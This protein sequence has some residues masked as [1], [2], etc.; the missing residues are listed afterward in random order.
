MSV[1]ASVLGIAMLA[2][3]LPAAAQ[4]RGTVEFGAFGSRSSYDNSLGMSAS[5]GGGARIG[6]FLLPRLSVEFEAGGSNAGRTLGLQDVNVGVLSAR[7]TA[8]PVKA[9]AL[10]L[11]LGA[12]VD[13]IDTH[14]LESYGVHGLVG[15]KLALTQSVALRLDGILSHLSNGGHNNKG[16]HLGLVVYRSPGGGTTMVRETMAATPMMTHSDSVSASETARL[17]MASANYDALRDSL[18]RRSLGTGPAPSSISALATMQQVIYFANDRSDL[19]DSARAILGEKVA[20]FRANPAMRIVIVGFASEPGTVDY[21]MALG[22]RRAESAR[23]YLISQ[24]VDP[25][26]IEISTR[27]E[28]QLVVE[29]PGES[30]DA[31][32]RRGT[33]RLQVADPHLVPRQ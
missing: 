6:A 23:A 21:N 24:G 8:V 27:G 30:A 4:Q 17:R 3:A 1:R 10:S 28:G 33:F 2:G 22:L 13:H 29:G 12:G 19:S 14:F 26:R 7:L 31:Q 11:L 5:W 32:N 9:G 16:L 15:A 20:V 18:S 25:I